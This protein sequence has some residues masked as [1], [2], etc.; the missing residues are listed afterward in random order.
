[1]ALIEV[2]AEWTS[3]VTLSEKTLVCVNQ[4]P[5]LLALGSSAPSDTDDGVIL[6]NG[7]MGVFETGTVVRFRK[8]NIS[9][10][11]QIYTGPVA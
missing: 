4:G 7:F 3:P 9:R 2:T 6:R 8:P 1:M 10:R 5:V 11:A